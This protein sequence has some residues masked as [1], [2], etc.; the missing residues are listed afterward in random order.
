[1][2]I[3]K[4][5]ALG[6]IHGDVIARRGWRICAQFAWVRPRHPALCTRVPMTCSTA[7]SPPAMQFAV[8][9]LDRLGGHEYP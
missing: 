9:A 2:L 8:A 7:S 5:G 6:T 1:M 3:L 4:V